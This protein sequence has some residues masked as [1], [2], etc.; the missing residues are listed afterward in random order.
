[1]KWNNLKTFRCPRCGADLC[2]STLPERSH[3]YECCNGQ[4]CGFA[5]SKNKFTKIVTGKPII[6]KEE[7]YRPADEVP[8]SF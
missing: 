3:L 7:H 5:I 8:D 4:T 6:I 1:M 2:Q